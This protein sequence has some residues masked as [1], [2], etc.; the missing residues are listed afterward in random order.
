MLL[1]P[2]IYINFISQ[3][4]DGHS[5]NMANLKYRLMTSLRGRFTV[6]QLL[7]DIKV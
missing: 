6:H 1:K 3:Y 4:E 7:S 2:D 5:L